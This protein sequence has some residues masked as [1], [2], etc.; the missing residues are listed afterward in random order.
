MPRLNCTPRTFYSQA[1]EAGFFSALRS[2]GA[3]KNIKGI[4]DTLVASFPTRISESTLRDLIGIFYRYEIDM[5]QLKQF[6]NSA[7]EDW[8][9][10]TKSFWFKR[11]F[12]S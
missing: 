7:N 12:K 11:V 1:D 6:R 4:K 9:H 2:V 10:D 8:F 3:A 5:T